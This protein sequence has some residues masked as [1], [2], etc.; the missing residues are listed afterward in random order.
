MT[1]RR[2]LPLAALALLLLVTNVTASAAS[3]G[4]SPAAGTIPRHGPPSQLLG[5]NVQK[6][7]ISKT[8]ASDTRALYV[9]QVGLYSFRQPSKLLEATLE[10]ARFRS[11]APATSTDFQASIVS[12]LGGS[13]PTVVRVGGSVIYITTSKGLTIAVWFKDGYMMAL[14]I[15]NTYLQP[16]E[17]VRMALQINP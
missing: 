16:K 13:L 4:A 7:N 3:P 8:L 17:L 10:I 12:G 2:A 15:R 5:L 1:R 9:D 6:E 11:L 14:A